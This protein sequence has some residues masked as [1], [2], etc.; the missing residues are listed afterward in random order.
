[1][2]LVSLPKDDLRTGIRYTDILHPRSLV[3]LL[4]QSIK[5]QKCIIIHDGKVYDVPAGS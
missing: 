2:H 3:R 5:A 1:M 4:E